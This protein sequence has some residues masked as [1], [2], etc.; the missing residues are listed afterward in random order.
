MQEFVD[1]KSSEALKVSLVVS[2]AYLCM[3]CVLQTTMEGSVVERKAQECV[4]LRGLNDRFANY[5]ERVNQLKCENAELLS[6]NFLL[7]G[8]VKD[9]EQ[10]RSEVVETLKKRLEDAL[11][12]RVRRSAVLLLTIQYQRSSK[13]K[14]DAKLA[15][16]G[17]PIWTALSRVGSGGR[18]VIYMMWLAGCNFICR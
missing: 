10:Q 7:R 12:E 13:P 9:A 5:I 14:V 17:I 8:Q 18:P 16:E 15:A 1:P 4:Q 11:T 6:K 2:S 3:F